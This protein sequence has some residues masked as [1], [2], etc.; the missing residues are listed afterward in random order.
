[1]VSSRLFIT[2]IGGIKM[3]SFKFQEP[4][5]QLSSVSYTSM[6]HKVGVGDMTA[7]F[8]QK[9]QLVSYEAP[10]QT[11]LKN[12]YDDQSR[13]VTSEA[14]N[15]VV[16]NVYQVGGQQLTKT[17]KIGNKTIVYQYQYD[18]LGREVMR[19]GSDQTLRYTLYANQVKL[20]SLCNEWN[21]WRYRLETLDGRV[22]KLY[23][24][25]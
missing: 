19:K 24:P 2:S 13:L 16:R 25:N 9:G 22:L 15:H 18:T 17:V 7:G 20:V 6:N 3:T 8:N 14:K 12:T 11:I 23:Y 21:K 1:M 4:D 10:Q 5:Q